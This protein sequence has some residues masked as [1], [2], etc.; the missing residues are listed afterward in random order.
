MGQPF[1]SPCVQHLFF[2]LAR[3]SMCNCATIRGSLHA[4]NDTIPDCPDCNR[5]GSFVAGPLGG[6]IATERG[7]RG[8]DVAPF[9]TGNGRFQYSC[10]GPKPNVPCCTGLWTHRGPLRGTVSQ[11]VGALG[12][13]TQGFRCTGRQGP[14]FLQWR[15]EV[16]S[17]PPPTQQ[18]ATSHADCAAFVCARALAARACL[19][20]FGSPTRRRR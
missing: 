12:S 19:R 5:P 9:A 16:G 20:G 18:N 15:A 2:C 3:A 14:K 17:V 4:G 6:G 10:S 11:A 13:A 8:D 1:F 7:A